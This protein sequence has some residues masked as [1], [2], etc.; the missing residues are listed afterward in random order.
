[1]M[2]I[3]KVPGTSDIFNQFTMLIAQDIIT[4]AITKAA[5]VKS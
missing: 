3:E 5:G 2:H 1:M 4:L